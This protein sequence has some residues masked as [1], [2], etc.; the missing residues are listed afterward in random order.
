MHAQVSQQLASMVSPLPNA[1]VNAR[2]R[3]DRTRSFVA[4]V[5][6]TWRS[7]Q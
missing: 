2:A 1:I 4:F 5:T 7:R 3:L 6:R